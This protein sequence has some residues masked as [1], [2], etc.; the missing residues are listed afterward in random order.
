MWDD[1]SRLRS[2]HDPRFRTTDFAST[3]VSPTVMSF[4]LTFCNC[5]LVPISISSF[6]SSFNISQSS[7]IQFLK[8]CMQS[9]IAFNLCRLFDIFALLVTLFSVNFFCCLSLVLSLSLNFALLI[10]YFQKFVVNNKFFKL[11]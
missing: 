10:F 5:C 9:R 6:L 1:I 3:T 8:S 2:N 11:E 4:K 7:I